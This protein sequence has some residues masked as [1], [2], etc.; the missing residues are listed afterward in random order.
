MSA[1]DTDHDHLLQRMASADGGSGDKIGF[2]DGDCAFSVALAHSV[3]SV[4]RGSL[5]VGKGAE[6]AATLME[7]RRQAR[8]ESV[9]GAVLRANRAAV[10]SA[11]GLADGQRSAQR[12][13]LDL[14]RLGKVRHSRLAEFPSAPS[15]R[16]LF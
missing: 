14:W 12:V 2:N 16:E 13:A 5:S 10:A 4:S 1:G 8:F 11:A 3:R 7:H 15:P 6:V 9:V